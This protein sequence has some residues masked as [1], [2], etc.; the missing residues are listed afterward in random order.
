[1]MSMIKP[2]PTKSQG[3]KYG[4]IASHR[5]RQPRFGG[6]GM[7]AGG[8]YYITNELKEN[9]QRKIPTTPSQ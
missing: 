3:N 4:F 5:R 6:G 9:F 8:S 7:A 2:R 1:M